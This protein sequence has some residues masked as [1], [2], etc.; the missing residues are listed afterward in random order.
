VERVSSRFV[1]NY[2]ATGRQRWENEISQVAI[3]PLP[4]HDHANLHLLLLPALELEHDTES[5]I[6][7][8]VVSNEALLAL[9][10]TARKRNDVSRVDVVA[11]DEDVGSGAVVD[12]MT[13]WRGGEAVGCVENFWDEGRGGAVLEKEGNEEGAK[14]SCSSKAS[15]KGCDVSLRTHSDRGLLGLAQQMLRIPQHDR[16]KLPRQLLQLSHAR[17]I[18]S[19]LSNRL[20]LR[21]GRRRPLLH[22]W[23]SALIDRLSRNFHRTSTAAPLSTEIDGVVPARWPAE[24][25]GE[26]FGGGATLGRSDG[27][28]RLEGLLLLLGM[29]LGGRRGNRGRGGRGGKAVDGERRT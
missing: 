4:S 12:E 16:P 5:L 8:L 21:L 18:P 20:L 23:S 11:M 28:R 15:E 2:K 7:V 26:T 17:P 29:G 27:R 13:V 3:S 1:S 6:D 24:E 9:E 22:H 25:A 19:I 10:V 14:I